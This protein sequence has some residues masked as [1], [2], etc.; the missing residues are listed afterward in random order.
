[1]KRLLYT[2]LFMLLPMAALA[3]EWD[4]DY[5]AEFVVNHLRYVPYLEDGHSYAECLGFEEGYGVSELSIPQSVSYEGRTLR[6]VSIGY[7]AFA[8]SALVTVTVP[9]SVT[10]I[11]ESAFFALNLKKVTLLSRQLTIG[12]TAFPGSIEE[13]H[14]SA[15]V[16]P[17]ASPYFMIDL[18]TFEPGLAPV[19]VPKGSLAAYMADGVW[20]TCNLL[21][22]GTVAVKVELTVQA[23]RGGMLEQL[24]RAQSKDWKQA[25]SLKVTGAMNADDMRFVRDSLRRLNSLDMSAAAV[26][27]LPRS[28]FMAAKFTKVKLPAEL[29]SIGV[30]AFYSCTAIDTLIVP[31]GVTSI[32]ADAF[33]MCN[34]LEYLRLPSTLLSLGNDAISLNLSSDAE[35]VVQCDAFFPPVT[36]SYPL[37]CYSGS[38]RVLVPAV[39][40][41]HYSEAKYWKDMDLEPAD[42]RPAIV[43][44]QEPK[45][46]STDIVPQDYAPVLW[47]DRKSLNGTSYG[48]LQLQGGGTFRTAGLSLYTDLFHARNYSDM[49]SAVLLPDGVQVTAPQVEHR[50]TAMAGY[51]YFISFPFDVCLSDVVTGTNVT[52]WVVRSYSSVNRASGI[53]N[54]WTDVPAGGTLKANRGYIWF[55]ATDGSDNSYGYGDMVQFSVKAATETGM[56]MLET[57]DVAVPLQTVPATYQ[58][59]CNWNLVGNPFQTYFDISCLDQ[60]M[61]VT[62]WD[63]YW[64]TYRTYSPADDSYVLKPNEPMFLQKPDGAESLVF[65]S[66]GR[67][68]TKEKKS[69]GG[70]QGEGGQSEGGYEWGDDSDDGGY[71]WGEMV[72]GAPQRAEDR[73]IFNFTLTDGTHMDETRVVLNSAA[74]VLYDKRNDAVKFFSPD[75]AVPQLYTLVDGVPCSINERAVADGRVAVGIRACGSGTCTVSMT[76]G[77][78]SVVLEDRVTGAAVDLSR[79]SY[80]FTPAAGQTD[81]RFTLAFGAVTEVGAVRASD[82]GTRTYDIGGRDAGSAAERGLY[83]RNGNKY[84][85]K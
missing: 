19:Y 62:V 77:S 78:G 42:I 17:T 9:E 33:S 21:E 74:T 37:Y 15:S 64:S 27:E 69:D 58:H 28:A 79:E 85:A 72:I 30:D 6:V 5:G 43:M 14:L 82:C 60:T 46:I 70:G 34:G 1:M 83:I 75:D 71:E 59:N 44:L 32:A 36:G 11:D 4:F 80:T 54:Q 76:R 67:M 16:P 38:I 35:A 13:L 25:V 63:D 40:I 56:T 10:Y 57:A 45:V 65:K 49:A 68:P 41:D 47:F 23:E 61:P 29:V 2:L 22:E 55:F 31:E 81:G 8:L 20:A 24:V 53:S 84:Y 12:M 66:A 73:S 18:N 26:R 48:T 3:S 7:E 39:S 51:W 52:N 50:L